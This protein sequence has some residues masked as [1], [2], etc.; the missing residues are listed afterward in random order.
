M[1][2]LQC[3]ADGDELEGVIGRKRV[4]LAAS[5]YGRTLPALRPITERTLREELAM[6]VEL[7]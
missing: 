7:R 6:E 4:R 1:E 5:V 2:G 3:R